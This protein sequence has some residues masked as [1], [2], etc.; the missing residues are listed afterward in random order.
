MNRAPSARPVTEVLS[1]AI[2]IQ[3]MFAVTAAGCL[4]LGVAGTRLLASG[5]EQGAR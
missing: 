5:V 4:V 2:G 3:P 1:D